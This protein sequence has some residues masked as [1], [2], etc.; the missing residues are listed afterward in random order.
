MTVSIAP[1][2]YFVERIGG[3]RVHVT[4]MVPTGSD[5]HTFEPSPGQMRALSEADLYLA[6]GENFEQ[7]WMA[8]F[9]AVNPDMLVVDT[10][11][12]IERFAEED[13]DHPTDERTLDPH[14]WVSPSLV[15]VLAQATHDALVGLDAAHT[16][17]YDAGL[18]AFLVDID[19]LDAE[20]RSVLE[21]QARRQFIVFHPAW[22]YFARDYGLEQI[23]VEIG[24][25][26]PS[27]AEMARLVAFA[28]K[29][30]IRVILAQP[31][32]ST[33]AAETIARE[34][35][36]EV[37]LISPLAPDWLDNMRRVADAFTRALE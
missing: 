1:Q 6:I 18:A 17:A 5:P 20:I 24:G 7:T 30:N 36:G 3:D 37:V 2:Q 29:E 34:I 4:V 26:E 28:R 8:R 21:D 10:F 32:F 15:K 31:E 33:L 22:A 25:Q 27:A 16:S 12:G 11:A 13:A 23:P 35:G 14:I 9:R 19:A